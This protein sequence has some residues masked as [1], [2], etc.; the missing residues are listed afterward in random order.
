LTTP[1]FKLPRLTIRQIVQATA[2]LILVAAAFYFLYRFHQVFLLLFVAIVF[3]TAIRPVVL[4]LNKLGLPR[5]AGVILVYICLVG[6]IAAV[7]ILL[8][9]LF[10]RQGNLFADTI[11]ETYEEVRETML[12]NPNF[13]IWRMAT[14][15]PESL[16][17]TPAPEQ[18]VEEEDVIETV[19]QNLE[20]I[21]LGARSIFFVL[22]VL[23]LAF[24]W[25]LDGQK[26]QTALLLL[27]PLDHRENA[28]EII[29]EIQKRLGAFIQGQTLLGL[30]IGSLSFLAYMIIGLPYALGLAIVAG[31]MEL[32]P[33]IG[34]ILGAVP[35]IF[36]AYTVGP[37]KVLWV[38]LATVIIQQFE[39][40]FLVPRVM[41]RSV[42]VNPLVTLM[43]LTTF[44]TLFGILG[45]IVAIPL[46]AIIQLLLDRFVIDTAVPDEK[47]IPGRDKISVLR[48][49]VQELTKD[50]RKAIREKEIAAD[51][52]AD[53]VEDTIEAIAADLD[54]TLAA[55]QEEWEKKD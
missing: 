53:E 7:I 11:P 49:D 14:E 17:I 46:A 25:T 52:E 3:S 6:I 28:R 29:Q 30:V 8:L 41:K 31:I 38:L 2:L 50:I 4:R 48:Y 22:A 24:Y 34:P 12:E 20:L 27:F 32:V 23:L 5:E 36:V 16:S 43:A 35:A 40:N 55:R 13:F 37:E 45:A 10:V 47:T 21:G 26:N 39:N 42:G 44:G 9:P 1:E 15:M 51:H 18:P 33:V 54:S 19:G